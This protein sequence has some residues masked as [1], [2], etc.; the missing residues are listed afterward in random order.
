VDATEV[1]VKGTVQV[2]DVTDSPATV[3]IK[4]RGE[5][6]CGFWKADTAEAQVFDT[7]APTITVAL[8]PAVLW[9]PNHKLRDVTATVVA[10]DNCP[11]SGFVLDSIT[12]SEPD[13]GSGDGDTANDIQNAAVGTPDTSFRLR[14]ERVGSGNG[15]TYT[16]TYGVT[17][18][19]GNQATSSAMVIVPHNKK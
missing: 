15:R 12:S 5:D 13:N 3:I 6:A 2:S 19:S 18:G 1:S 9:P 14:A 8:D 10:E 4:V 17:D 11:A 7:T 16:A